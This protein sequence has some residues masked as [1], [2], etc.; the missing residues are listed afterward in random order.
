[1]V[2]SHKGVSI[3][4]AVRYWV[5]FTPSRS[6]P[7]FVDTSFINKTYASSEMIVSL[8]PSLPLTIHEV[9]RLFRKNEVQGGPFK[10]IDTFFYIF[11]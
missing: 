5:I 8:A 7:Y 10:F 9:C 3:K 1:M 2:T 11:R 4:Y 6:P